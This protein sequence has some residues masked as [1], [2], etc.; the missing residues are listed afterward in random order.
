MDMEGS[1]SSTF[2]I[3]YNVS[4]GIYA[5]MWVVPWQPVFVPTSASRYQIHDNQFSATGQYAEGMYLYDN[6]TNPWIQAAVWN[7]TIEL[8]E[9]MSEGIGVYNT[10]PA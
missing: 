8:Q 10:K 1:E 6:T 4:S 3:S 5:S 9:T 2:D 7:N